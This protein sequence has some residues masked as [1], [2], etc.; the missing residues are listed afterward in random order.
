MRYKRFDLNLL[1]VLDALLRE[2]SVSRAAEHLNLSQPAISAALGRVRQHLND[3]IL[4]LH[5]KTMVPTA[6]ALSM[7]PIVSRA[8]ADIDALITAST[9]F[10]P[11]TSRRR[12]RICAS[13]YVTVVLLAPLMVEL[14]ASAPGLSFDI[15]PPGPDVLPKFERGEID[16]LLTPMQFTAESHPRHLL[17]EERHVV[18]GCSKNPVLQEP[19]SEE[20]FFGEG[21][22]VIELDH[23]Q[24]YAE[25]ALGELNRRR[26]IDVVCSSFLAVPWVLLNSRLLAV[27]H[28]RLARM[29]V[30]SLPLKIVPMP[31]ELPL[32]PEMVQHHAARSNDDGI[33]WLLQHL[34]GMAKRL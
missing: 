17:F 13:D 14:A 30:T 21:H 33:Q 26:R 25:Q 34:L 12:F 16:L 23:S 11:A 10:D 8:L 3:E 24:T 19:L 2:K 7:A 32:M 18:V 15:C 1:V 20:T 27:M 4:I 22:V 31:I 28:E 5:G 29:V 6:H 9:V